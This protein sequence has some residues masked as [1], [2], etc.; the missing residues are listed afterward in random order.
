MTVHQTVGSPSAKSTLIIQFLRFGAVGTSGF[1]IDTAIVYGLVGMLGL[2][3]AG[4]V[5]YLVAAT[6]CWALNRVWT[7]RGRGRGL[8]H[9]Q[10]ATYLLTNLSGLV[11]NRG[12]Y[13][14]MVTVVPFCAAQ[15]VFAIAAGAVAGMMVN[16]TMSRQ[17]VF[18]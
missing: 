17:V 18:R 12:T 14:A 15:P 16:F 9:Q 1:L 8:A 7:F 6:S 5:S 10:W 13:F 4:M 2:Y 3:G 11:F